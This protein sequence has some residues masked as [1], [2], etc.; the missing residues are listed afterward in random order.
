M[1]H[2][3]ILRGPS[4]GIPPSS[5]HSLIGGT[6]QLT[7]YTFPLSAEKSEKKKKKD[8]KEGKKGG[9][10]RRSRSV[11][12]LGSVRLASAGDVNRMV[13]STSIIYNTD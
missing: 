4:Y 13:R 10:N 12:W 1:F 7:P 5:P 9:P 11:V 3:Y 8:G 6:L 2:N